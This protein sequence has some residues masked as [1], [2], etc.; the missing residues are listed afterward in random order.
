[1]NLSRSTLLKIY[2]SLN[3]S[4]LNKGVSKLSESDDG[5]ILYI[6]HPPYSADHVTTIFALNKD[7]WDESIEKI[8]NLKQGDVFIIVL[9]YDILSPSLLASITKLENRWVQRR[10]GNEHRIE[11]VADVSNGP[12]AGE[13]KYSYLGFDDV[14]ELANVIKREL[15]IQG[16]NRI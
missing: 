6:Q 1:M 7:K 9:P 15:I 14:E 8:Y 4:Q 12:S 3:F 5:G 16:G 10:T 11:V 2:L 13:T